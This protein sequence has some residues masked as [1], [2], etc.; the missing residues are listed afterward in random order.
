MITVTPEAAEQ[1]KLSAKQSKAE[2]LPLR[3]AAQRQ[4]DGSL[5]YA[6]GFA[7]EEHTEDLSFRSEGIDIVVSPMSIDLLSNTVIDF[8]ELDTGEKNFIFKN[9]NDPNYQAPGN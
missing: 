2:G 8:V 5:H 1:I 6:L 4:D 3:V 7:E 9:P